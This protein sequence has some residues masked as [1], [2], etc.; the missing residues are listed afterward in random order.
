MVGNGSGAAPNAK[1]QPATAR[2]LSSVGNNESMRDLSNISK[3]TDVRNPPN[4][5]DRHLSVFGSDDKLRKSGGFTGRKSF[6]VGRGADAN[7]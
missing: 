3:A 7:L 6:G 5:D 2:R 1:P 4:Q